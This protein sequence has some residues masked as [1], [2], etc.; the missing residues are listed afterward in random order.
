MKEDPDT[1]PWNKHQS[2]S[3]K[4]FIVFLETVYLL[5]LQAVASDL[6]S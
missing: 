6:F 2:G 3:M 5:P 4:T 1:G